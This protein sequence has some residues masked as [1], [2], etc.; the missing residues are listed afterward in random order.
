[1]FYNLIHYDFSSDD[2]LIKKDVTAV[3]TGEENKWT[4]HY[5]FSVGKNT[6]NRSLE[7][8]VYVSSVSSIRGIKQV[9]FPSLSQ[10]TELNTDN[11]PTPTLPQ[12]ASV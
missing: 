7:R 8:Q 4:I 5:T 11:V 9:V 10:F 6:R 3:L 1:M 12:F 2:H